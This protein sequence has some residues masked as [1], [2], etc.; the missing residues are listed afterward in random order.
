LSETQKKVREEW[1]KIGSKASSAKLWQILE[2]HA[3]DMKK[4]KVSK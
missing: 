2:R 4:N 3:S 1:K